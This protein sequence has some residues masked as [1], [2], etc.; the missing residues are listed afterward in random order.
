[1]APQAAIRKGEHKLIWEFESDRT[2]LFD[3]DLDISETTD[4][5]RFR[6]EIAKDMH[7]ELK[8]YFKSVDAK[9]PTMNV[10]YDPARDP[11]LGT[12]SR[13]FGNRGMPAGRSPRRQGGTSSDPEN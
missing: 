5:S 8:E 13:R 4:L 11:G 2:I 7:S 3:L 12:R 1:M 9:L 10:D 6:P